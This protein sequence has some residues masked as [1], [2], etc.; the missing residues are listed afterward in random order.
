MLDLRN[1]RE[2]WRVFTTLGTCAFAIAIAMKL[3]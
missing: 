1:G 2:T 3:I